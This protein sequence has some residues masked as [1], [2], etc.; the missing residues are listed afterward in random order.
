VRIGICL[1]Q[2]GHGTTPD[3]VDEFITRADEAGFDSLWA[4]EHLFRP[5]QPVS[6]YGG[7]A[8]KAWPIQ[9]Q[10]LLAPFEL[11]AYTAARTS[12]CTIGMSIAVAGYHHP[13]DLAKRAATIDEMSRGRMVLG[14]GVGWCQDEY[15]LVGAPFQRRG[16]VADELFAGLLAC[17]GP[18]PVSYEGTY[19]QVPPSETSPKPHHGERVRLAGGFLSP[20]GARRAAHYC[21]VWQPYGIDPD[22]A[23]RRCD[24]VDRIAAD[25]FGRGPLELSLRVTMAP[26]I[27]GLIEPV[28]SSTPGRWVG[29]IEELSERV[30]GAA[31]A[32]CDELVIDT[33]FA[34][35]RSTEDVWLAQPEYLAPLVVIAH[36]G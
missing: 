36:G 20:T 26:H 30:R 32:G 35:E 27:P 21:D 2:L 14:I 11:L 34:V 15:D 31:D 25:E 12:R 7:V 33:S 3:T 6:A 18:N 24:A 23:R 1:P 22:E 10:R 19:F 4:Q 16:V 5:L 29:G 17:W 28:G 13:V 8:G 9:Q